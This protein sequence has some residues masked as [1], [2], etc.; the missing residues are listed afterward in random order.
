VVE[1]D[2]VMNK[3]RE[4]IYAERKK[5]LSQES[6]KE[7]V[8]KMIAD[9]ITALINAHLPGPHRDDWDLE[10][11][12]DGLHAILPVQFSVEQLEKMARQE[13]ENFALEVAEGLYEQKEQE[14]TPEGMRQLERLVM[15]TT[16]DRQ[17]VDHLTA[18]DDLRE[19]I[20]LRAYGQRDPL[21]EY[22]NEAYN[23]FQGL[24][25]SIQRSIVHTIYHVGLHRAEE[26]PRPQRVWTN[27]AE[28]SAPE[29]ARVARKIGR[30][31]PCPC[32]SGKKYKRCCGR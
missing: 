9:E 28:E 2:D 18:I 22:K 1:Y 11:L 23:M 4:I 7:A 21:V 14:Q 15:L 27:K 17:W 10:A 31:D 16:I 12:V 3:Q 20:G 30:N 29:P 8:Q 32:G 6:M 25:E 24:L 19:G 13:V 26:S 5:I